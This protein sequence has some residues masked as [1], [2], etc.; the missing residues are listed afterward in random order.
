MKKEDKLNEKKVF[1]VDPEG[2][3]DLYL[4]IQEESFPYRLVIRK[5]HNP[6]KKTLGASSKKIRACEMY[7]RNQDQ[8][9]FFE[10][11]D[12]AKIQTT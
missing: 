9:H 12:R 11:I 3:A 6:E 2:L 5:L 4:I 7:F 1:F 10:I 8:I